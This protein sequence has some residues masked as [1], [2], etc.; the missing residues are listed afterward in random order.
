MSFL[1]HKTPDVILKLDNYIDLDKHKISIWFVKQVES[2]VPIFNSWYCTDVIEKIWSRRK[3]MWIATAIV[4]YGSLLYH[5]YATSLKTIV[6]RV[7]VVLKKLSIFHSTKG[8]GPIYFLIA[9]GLVEEEDL[10]EYMKLYRDRALG[11]KKR[12]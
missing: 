7:V 1:L 9:S 6:F 2:M 10:K 11:F 4:P 8:H 3:K 12:K 5:L